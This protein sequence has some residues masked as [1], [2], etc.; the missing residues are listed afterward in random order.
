VSTRVSHARIEIYEQTGEVSRDVRRVPGSTGVGGDRGSVLAVLDT[1]ASG[2]VSASATLCVTAPGSTGVDG[3]LGRRKAHGAP[4]A[5]E[6]LG[7]SLVGGVECALPVVGQFGDAPEELVG[8]REQ[9]ESRMTMAVGVP[10]EELGEPAASVGDIAEP[11]WVLRGR[12]KVGVPGKALLALIE[13]ELGRAP[14]RPTSCTSQPCLNELTRTAGAR[15]RRRTAPSCCS[16]GHRARAGGRDQLRDARRALRGHRGRAARAG[17][18]GRARLTED[19]AARGLIPAPRV[20]A[21]AVAEAS[22]WRAEEA[23]P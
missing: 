2:T 14:R 23:S 11:A 8:R 22:V 10:V 6:A 17:G 3:D 16:S 21:R 5:H 19:P 1:S 7:V 18:H 12:T 4:S 15:S 20:R 9:R 13:H